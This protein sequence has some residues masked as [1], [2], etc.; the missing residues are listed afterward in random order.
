M[1]SSGVPNAVLERVFTSTAT[2]P[3]R[4]AATMSISPSAHRQFRVEYA[5]P[6]AL[7]VIHGQ[8][9]AP[10]AQDILGIHPT[11]SGSDGAGFGRPGLMP[12]TAVDETAG[13]RFC[14]WRDAGLSDP[15]I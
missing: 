8:L 6:G 3:R 9:L 12:E 14:G 11:T 5:D 7:Q 1:A 15:L 10:P 4:S 2:R 13:T